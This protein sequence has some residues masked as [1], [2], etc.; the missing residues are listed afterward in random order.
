[1]IKTQ[2]PYIDNNGNERENLIKT[3]S[4]IGLR[5]L[6]N[7]TG[8]IYD[9]A[10]DIY[11]SQYTYSETDEYIEI[12]DGEEIDYRTAYNNLAAEVMNNETTE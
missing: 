8:G 2:Y 6:Q 5:I 7:E 12:E 11:P 10:V 3:Y 1:M 4:D 9:E